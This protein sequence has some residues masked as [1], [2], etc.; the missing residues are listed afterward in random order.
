MASTEKPTV[1]ESQVEDQALADTGLVTTANSHAL[2]RKL[3]NRQLQLIAI[4]GSI[5]TAIF[6]SIG[7][8]L[9]VGG[10]GSLLIGYSIYCC[11]LALVNNGVAEMTT[12][13]PVS[14]G[15]VSLVGKWTDEAL[16]FMVGWNFFLYEALIVP[17][18]I[19]ALHIVLSYWSDNVPAV[20]VCLVTSF[21]YGYV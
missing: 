20:A 10:A 1:E 5:G 15:F 21:L 6:V 9:S 17:F 19:T 8:A 2:Q 11:I 12:Y 16:G 14:G 3:N 4:G 13:M 7:G 18:E